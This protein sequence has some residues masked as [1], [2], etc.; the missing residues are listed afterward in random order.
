MQT[1]TFLYST[2]NLKNLKQDAAN[3]KCQQTSCAVCLQPQKITQ[4]VL[5]SLQLFKEHLMDT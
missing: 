4:N 5:Y 1:I 3:L 2:V